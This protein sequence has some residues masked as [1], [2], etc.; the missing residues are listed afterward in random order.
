M[1]KAVVFD[2]D[3][4]LL[5]FNRM[6]ETSVS[7][8]AEAMMDA[9]LPGTRD[10]IL[11]GIYEVY[12][13]KGIEAQDVFD[14]FLTEK[15]GRVDLKV[16]AAG[17]VAYRKAKMGTM[18]L[19][20]GARRTIIEL[21][22]KGIKMGLLSDAP[23]LQAWTRLAELGLHHYFDAVVTLDDTQR[24]KP[25]PEPFR[26]ILLKLGVEPQEAIMVGD[27]A[28]RDMEGA[29]RVGMRTAF[30]SYG[31]GQSPPEGV[32]YVLERIDDLIA[33]IEKERQ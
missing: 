7:A 13:R 19:F 14:C 22:R 17:V 2:L 10:E 3:N 33:I 25:D 27:W 1:I 28:E 15:L 5:D 29:R 18:N 6:K 23:G 21:L 20:P 32:D 16:L 31:S 26:V 24:K 12:E 11:K 4:T 9:G 30:A 8:A